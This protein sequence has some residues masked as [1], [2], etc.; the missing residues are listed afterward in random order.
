[1]WGIVALTLQGLE[2]ARQLRTQF[3][4]SEIYTLSKWEV[5]D[6]T[7]IA[8]ELHD[9]AGVLFSKHKVLVFIMASGIVV[10]CIARHLKDKTTDPAVLVMDEKGKYVISL[11]S[12]HLG[13]ANEVASLIAAKTGAEAVI[14]TSSDVNG[15]TSVDM[16]AKQHGLIIDDMHDAK[17][18][19][20]MMVNGQRIAQCNDT[21][22]IISP[23][24]SSPAEDAEGMVVITGK[25]NIRKS[26]P[27]VKL[28]PVNMII[29][30]GC[31]KGTKAE[32]ILDFV[33]FLLLENNIDKRSVRCMATIDLKKDEPGILDVAAHMNLP[34]LNFS[35]EQIIEVEHL[36]Q[37]SAFVKEKIGVGCVCEPAAYLAGKRKGRFVA[38]KSKRNGMT[39]SLFEEEN[40]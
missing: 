40:L 2:K 35:K 33:T 26:V 28:I 6:A 32:D 1:M 20:A 29:G 14:T 9:F 25:A 39:L 31:R 27:F 13:G 7:P 10:R 30:I 11:L 21:L 38:S 5:P 16:I 15:L 19:T 22:A 17:V 12:G 24:F 18:I 23:Y 4:D 37:P 8:G 36:F 3:P 34:L